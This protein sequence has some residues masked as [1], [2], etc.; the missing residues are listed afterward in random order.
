[1]P[2]TLLGE[3][4]CR[5]IPARHHQAQF[6]SDATTKATGVPSSGGGSGRHWQDISRLALSSIAAWLRDDLY[7]EWHHGRKRTVPSAAAGWDALSSFRLG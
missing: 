5:F 4:R 3:R 6:F 1:M 7:L 2:L